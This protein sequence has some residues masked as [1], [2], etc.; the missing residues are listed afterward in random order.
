M[1]TRRKWK[2]LVPAATLTAVSFTMTGQAA[3]ALFPPIWPV[4][5]PPTVVSPPPSSPPVIVVPPVSPPP[6]VP[7]PPPPV[8][9]PPVSPPTPYSPPPMHCHTPNTVPEP[10]SLVAGLAGLATAAGWA[11]RRRKPSARAAE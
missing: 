4:T 7:P 11:A 10:S 9:S 2:K 3:Y 8:I 6:F 1:S 5:V